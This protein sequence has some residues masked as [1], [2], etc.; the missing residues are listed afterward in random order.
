MLVQVDDDDNDDYDD[1]EE[2]ERSQ[3]DGGGAM[4]KEVAQLGRVTQAPQ[5]GGEGRVHARGM[6]FRMYR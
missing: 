4:G 5:L 1:T 3:V 6:H 2:T